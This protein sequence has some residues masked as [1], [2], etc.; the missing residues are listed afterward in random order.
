MAGASDV[1]EICDLVLDGTR[2]MYALDQ[3][4]RAAY[5]YTPAYLPRT[6]AQGD[7]T[8]DKQEFFSVYH[9]KDWSNGE[10]R[11]HQA[12]NA[13]DQ[14]GFY[15][16]GSNVDN[17]IPG[18]ISAAKT[19]TT[20]T[21]AA[22]VFA[23]VGVVANGTVYYV[24]TTNLYTIVDDGTI[25]DKGAH[26]LGATPTCIATDGKN[27]YIGGTTAGKIRRYNIGGAAFSDYNTTTSS[28]SLVYHNNALYGYDNSKVY[29]YTPGGGPVAATDI[30]LP[31]QDGTATALTGVTGKLVSVG[32]KLYIVRQYPGDPV[33]CTIYSYDGTTWTKVSEMPRNFSLWEATSNNGVI[34]V[35]GFFLEGANYR[36]AILFWKEGNTDT[37]WKSMYAST[38]AFHCALAPWGNGIIFNDPLGF[39]GVGTARIVKWD[40]DT[41][42]FSTVATAS[43]TTG[44]ILVSCGTFIFYVPTLGSGVTQTIWG[45]SGT[46]AS[47]AEID[48][49]WIDLGVAA[50]KHLRG[51]TVDFVVDG[52]TTVDLLV[53]YDDNPTYTSIQT[54][55]TSGQEYKIDPPAEGTAY[56]SFSARIKLNRGVSSPTTIKLKRVTFRSILINTGV[57]SQ[58][59]M[60]IYRLALTG[61]DGDNPLRYSNG[62][63]SPTDG[64]GLHQA[65]QA[66][67]AKTTYVTITDVMGTYSGVIDSLKV[68]QIRKAEFV[69]E[70]TVREV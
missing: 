42:S 44:G 60:R 56:K 49:S 65:L 4:Q 41:G 63:V 12:K 69:A 35:S 8:D 36:P 67:A 66:T 2:Y 30:S 20:V 55:I 40:A 32:G 3:D 43:G 47:V 22:A 24:T 21:T 11:K 23:A 29:R 1:P 6:N 58:R 61:R 26:G 28:T 13:D 70:V 54:T 52:G 27:V 50:P 7:L 62:E 18:E 33:G 9:Q 31:W 16:R 38:S 34:Y 19:A 37:L 53:S 64:K 68:Y 45:G 15:Y 57:N 17:S 14:A 48:S 59:G 39:Y 51:V 25:A 10:E 5:T 46:F